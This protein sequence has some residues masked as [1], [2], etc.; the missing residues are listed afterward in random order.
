MVPPVTPQGQERKD[1]VVEMVRDR[2]GGHFGRL[3]PCPDLGRG[4]VA[5]L[6]CW[7]DGTACPYR[8]R[9]RMALCHAVRSFPGGAWN[10]RTLRGAG[11][12]YSI[13]RPRQRRGQHLS[14]GLRCAQMALAGPPLCGGTDQHSPREC[15]TVRTTRQSSRSRCLCCLQQPLCG[16]GGLL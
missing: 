1:A 15:G 7:A 5:T 9:H 2:P 11:Q 12:R 4:P 6:P 16:M 13:W 14:E 3:R 8:G 10:A